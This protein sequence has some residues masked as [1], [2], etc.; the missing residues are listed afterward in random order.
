MIHAFRMLLGG[1]IIFAGG[2]NLLFALVGILIS[3]F[4]GG[5][6]R[7]SELAGGIVIGVVALILLKLGFWIYPSAPEAVRSVRRIQRGEYNWKNFT[8]FVRGADRRQAEVKRLQNG[9]DLYLDP[10]PTNTFDP[11]AIRVHTRDGDQIGYIPAETAEWLVRAI[12]DGLN[13][14]VTVIE[15]TRSQRYGRGVKVHLTAAD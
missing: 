15:L 10:E 12:A 3:I 14:R 5:P 11:N 7:W 8:C 2:V 6:N 1:L 4:M 13:Y 9:Q